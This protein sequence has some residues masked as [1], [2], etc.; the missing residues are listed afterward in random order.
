MLFDWHERKA[1]ANEK[2]HGISFKEASTV[3]TDPLSLTIPDPLHSEQEERFII[4]GRSSQDRL[5][6]VV[7]AD[8]GERLRIISARLATAHERKWYEE[9]KSD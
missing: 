1:T 9:N 3:F 5:L 2:K 8:D 7:H 6:V 4:I